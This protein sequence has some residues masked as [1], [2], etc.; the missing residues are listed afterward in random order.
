M[1]KK[2]LMFLM[3]VCLF[4]PCMILTACGKVDITG[5]Y[6]VSS[7][8]MEML[9][10]SSSYSKED[11]Q[12]LKDKAEGDLTPEEQ[13]TLEMLDGI[14]VQNITFNEDGT[15][16]Y[17]TVV[18]EAVTVTGNWNLDGDTLTLTFAED[19]DMAQAGMTEMTFTVDGDTL[20]SDM[21]GVT[22]VFKKA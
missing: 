19:S 18:I 13:S 9:G 1:K 14:F 12:A 17:E 4:V 8:S 2:I 10:T 21:M 22:I 5:K 20:T 16:A 6:E 7:Y 11:Y 15:F 3:A